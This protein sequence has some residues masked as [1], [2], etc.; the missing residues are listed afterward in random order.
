M[1]HEE[2]SDILQFVAPGTS[3]R[4]GI[5]NVLRAKTGGLIVVG[6]NERVQKV[7]E[8]GFFIDCPFSPAALYELA[9]MDGAIILNEDGS[10]ILRANTQLI[11]ESGIPS[12]ETGIRHRSAERTAKQTSALVISIS[13]RRDVITLYR[14]QFRYTLNE[15]GVILAKANQAI[16]TLERYKTVFDQGI[17]DLGALE[18]EEL[19]TFAEVVQVTHRVGMVLKI[20]NELNKFINEL[21]TEG[22]LIRMQMQELIAGVEE[23]T[24]WLIRDY[25]HH[26][27]MDPN[28]IIEQLGKLPSEELMNESVIVKLLGYASGSTSDGNVY[29]RGYR[30]LHKIPRLP[31]VVIENLI[32]R[33]SHLN[34]IMKASIEVLD[35]VEGIGEVRARKI[36]QGLGRIQEQL[37]VDRNL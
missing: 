16:R 12:G 27:D 25:A 10:R 26:K 35:E 18:F 6:Y 21:G 29:P 3:L 17:T 2:I 22:R 13:Q 36:K 24:V 4:E 19:V 1:S 14:G 37:F 7:V 8:G 11:P 23:E 5:D 33:F 20:K 15:I 30:I 9:K 28:H 31:S 34:D 32:D